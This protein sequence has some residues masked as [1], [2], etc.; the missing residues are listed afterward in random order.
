MRDFF[1]EDK[2]YVDSMLALYGDPGVEWQRLVRDA[3]HALEF[4][5]TMHFLGGHLP[6]RSTVLDAGG[7]PGRYALAL[8][9]AGHRVVLYDVVPTLIDKAKAE[10][11]RESPEVRQ[12]CEFGLGDVRDLSDFAEGRF[13]TT[14]CLG[15]CLSHLTDPADRQ[16]AVRELVRVTR[17]DGLLCVGVVGYLAALRTLVWKFGGTP[18]TDGAYLQR[19]R[20]TGNGI[21]WHFFRADEL[22]EL[23]QA[24]GVNTIQMVGCEG[25]STGLPE[26]TNRLHEEEEKWAP[27]FEL[28]LRTASEP[29]VVDMAEHILYIGRVRPGVSGLGAPR[30]ASPRGGFAR[31]LT[32]SK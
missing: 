25:L 5:V 19:L 29:A 13:D 8:C 6:A 15:G 7:G 9:R 18:L 4:T 17:P 10:F 16:Q 12:L 20:Q 2:S 27:W 23:V 32:L 30:R 21:R 31:W 28:V 11:E 24:C 22:R 14:L 1:S 26:A 3:Y